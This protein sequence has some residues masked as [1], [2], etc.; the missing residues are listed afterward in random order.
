MLDF[1]TW[2]G[3]KVLKMLNPRNSGGGHG[4]PG[5]PSYLGAGHSPIMQLINEL[6]GKL[7]LNCQ[8]IQ[9]I[10]LMD[11]NWEGKPFP[12]S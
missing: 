10:T 2:E 6:T 8:E 3:Q 4:P 12:P 11:I 1:H 9:N 7:G 5:H